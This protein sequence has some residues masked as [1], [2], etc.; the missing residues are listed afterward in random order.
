MALNYKIIKSNNKHMVVE[1]KTDLVLGTFKSYNE[2][3]KLQV[4][5]NFG[6]CFDGNTPTFFV[7]SV[8]N[9]INKV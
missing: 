7:K 4:H 1:T 5:L 3:K 6:G 9:N 2:A 8:T